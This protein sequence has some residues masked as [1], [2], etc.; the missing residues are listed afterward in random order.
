MGRIPSLAA[1]LWVLAP[2][3]AA[4]SGDAMAGRALFIG[5][6]ALRNGGSPCGACHA[7][8]GESA[9][10]AASLGPELSQSFDG[11]DDTAIAGLLEDIPFPTMAPIYAGRPIAP[12]ERADLTAFLLQASGKPAPGGG[13]VAV[14]AGLLAGA[15]LLVMGA[16]ARRRPGSARAELLARAR[17]GAR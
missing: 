3:A 4:A 16:A 2:G 9:P 7:I 5:A 8:G 13:R 14:Y 12:D 15:L 17:G 10:F 6:R 11:L 1:V